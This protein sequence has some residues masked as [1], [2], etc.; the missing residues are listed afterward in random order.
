MSYAI[1]TA[2]AFA[3]QVQAQRAWLYNH[4]GRERADTFEAELRHALELL[5]EHPEMGNPVAGTDRRHWF[6]RRSRFHIYYR[7]RHEKKAIVLARLRHEKQRP[8]DW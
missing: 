4:R 3:R 1:V 6:L 5:A 2:P 8:I 7:V